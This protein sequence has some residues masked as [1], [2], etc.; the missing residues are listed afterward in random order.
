MPYLNV[1]VLSLQ[2][3]GPEEGGWWYEAG[4]PFDSIQIPEETFQ[5]IVDEIVER[6]RKIYPDNR[7]RTSVVYGDDDCYDYE[8]SISDEPAS[9]WPSLTPRYE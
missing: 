7:L 4:E 6:F 8:V 3:G 5:E 1:H 9:R 2:Y